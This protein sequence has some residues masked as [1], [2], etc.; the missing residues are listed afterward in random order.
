MRLKLLDDGTATFTATGSSTQ[1]AETTN[2]EIVFF[3]EGSAALLLKCVNAGRFTLTV[4]LSDMGNQQ[5]DL[6]PTPHVAMVG[7]DSAGKTTI[8]Y[9]MKFNDFLQAIP[10]KGF[11]HEDII[12]GRSKSISLGVWDVGGQE[13][14]RP[15]WRSYLRHMDGLVF[16]VD[17]NDKERLEEAKVEFQR[18]AQ[19]PESQ[20]LPILVLANK[21]DLPQALSVFDVEKALRLCELG[22]DTMYHTEAC[23]AMDWNALN[24]GLEKLHEMILKNKKKKRRTRKWR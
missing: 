22:S 7:L 10:T 20:G 21:Q 3:A 5:I 6:S 24:H 23:N 1:K 9:R 2:P 11:N 16:V 8:L 18:I 12:F 17:S 14:L 15:L 19:A 13:K 4:E